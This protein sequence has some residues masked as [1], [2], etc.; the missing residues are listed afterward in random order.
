MYVINHKEK[1]IIFMYPKSGC[2][3]LRVLHAYLAHPDSVGETY[4]EDRH[5]GIQRRDDETITEHLDQYKDYHKILVYREPCE[6]VA[7][8]FFQKVCGVPAVSVK[9]KLYEEPVR[10]HVDMRTFKEFV[11]VLVTGRFDHDE[12]FQPQK[13][14]MPL[15]EFDQVLEL[16]NIDRLFINT[17]PDLHATVNRILVRKSN[18]NELTKVRPDIPYADYDFYTDL[19]GWLVRRE[20]PTYDAVLTPVICRKLSTEYGDDFLTG[21]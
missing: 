14:P 19:E 16:S 4:F 13:I 6:R 7:S 1:Y 20:V 5:H 8:L 11:D 10:L 2:S 3:T 17:R 12:H 9:G 15:R 18:W 21:I